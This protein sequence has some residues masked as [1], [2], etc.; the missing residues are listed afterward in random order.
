MNVSRLMKKTGCRNRYLSP[1]TLA[2]KRAPRRPAWI[3]RLIALVGHVASFQHPPR[4]ALYAAE[5]TAIDNNL[6][7]FLQ[8]VVRKHSV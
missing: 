1:S 3:C 8:A 4:L 7:Q 5:L 2:M 6:C